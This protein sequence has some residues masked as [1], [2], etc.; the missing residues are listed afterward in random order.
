MAVE[1][2]GTCEV[3]AGGAKCKFTSCVAHCLTIEEQ[4]LHLGRR[5]PR[6][7]LAGRHHLG[8]V[9]RDG[10]D[11]VHSGDCGRAQYRSY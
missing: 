5:R 11:N 8:D 1:T 3:L 10:R 7:R 6:R 4:D 9:A 2:M